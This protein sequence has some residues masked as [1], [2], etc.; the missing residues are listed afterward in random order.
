MVLLWTSVMVSNRIPEVKVRT[1]VLQTKPRSS[2]SV[3]LVTGAPAGGGGVL[4]FRLM[5]SSRASTSASW[6]AAYCRSNETL[7]N[8]RGS[9]D[10]GCEDL[11]KHCLDRKVSEAL[12]WIGEDRSH[13]LAHEAEPLRTAPSIC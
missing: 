13:I 12:I 7:W 2:N 10:K 1:T 3:N 11:W 9:D 8:C 4:A 5:S 6:G